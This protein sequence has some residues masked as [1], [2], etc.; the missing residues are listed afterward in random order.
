M[1][2]DEFYDIEY[3]E[4]KIDLCRKVYTWLLDFNYLRKNSYKDNKTPFELAREE[5]PNFPVAAFNLTP[6]I[7]DENNTLYLDTVAP[8]RYQDTPPAMITQL[9]GQPDPFDTD[10]QLKLI[11]QKYDPYD[12][13]NSTHGGYYLPSLHTLNIQYLKSTLSNIRYLL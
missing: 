1:V 9:T 6:I 12:K 10:D 13:L 7:L 3:I 5:F 2:E 4:S 8:H 11:L